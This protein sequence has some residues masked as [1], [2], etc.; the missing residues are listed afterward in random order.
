MM[1]TAILYPTRWVSS[2]SGSLGV[3][4]MRAVSFCLQPNEV[5]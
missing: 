4:T 3:E 2:S 1:N 5:A